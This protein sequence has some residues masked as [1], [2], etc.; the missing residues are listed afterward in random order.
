MK[1]SKYRD[2]P[3]PRP[4]GF[5]RQCLALHEGQA[6]V[7]LTHDRQL[8][9]LSLDGPTG[10]GQDLRPLSARYQQWQQAGDTFEERTYGGGALFAYEQGFGVVF[11]DQ[12][13]LFDTLSQP[14]P[15]VLDVLGPDQ[16]PQVLPARFTGRAGCPGA[17]CWL[18]DTNELAVA[19]EHGQ[20]W[21]RKLFLGLLRLRPTAGP[22]PPAFF[23]TLR[24]A[25]KADSHPQPPPAAFYQV[26]PA[27]PLTLSAAL[28]A[29]QQLPASLGDLID[30]P[31]LLALRYAAGQLQVATFGGYYSA[32]MGGAG[33]GRGLA[34]LA[35]EPRSATATALL[36]HVPT[37]WASVRLTADGTLAGWNQYLPAAQGGLYFYCFATGEVARLGFRQKAFTTG[38][39]QDKGEM[40]KWLSFDRAGRFIWVFSGGGA[41]VFEVH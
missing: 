10:P 15:R 39:P 38:L 2:F 32:R 1:F 9:R 11:L 7:A 41:S 20:F 8:W 16:Q 14:V 36:Q 17:A 26:A 22:L 37:H 31:Q 24:H 18:P 4:Y 13:L 34:L 12:V 40:L 23:R 35:V 29:E 25:L 21:G 6:A 30:A 3:T 28:R 33:T 19:Y 5:T 27:Q